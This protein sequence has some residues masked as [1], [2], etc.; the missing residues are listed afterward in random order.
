MFEFYNQL[1]EISHWI[2]VES[3]ATV[4]PLFCENGKCACD[5]R[6]FWDIDDQ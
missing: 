3:L 1:T 4:C 6:N 2:R 5:H